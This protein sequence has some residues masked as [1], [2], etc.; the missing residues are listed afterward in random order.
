MSKNIRPQ[1]FLR[2]LQRDTVDCTPVW[3]M[4]QAGRYLPEYKEIRKQAGDFL[5]LCKTPELAREVTLQPLNR[6][7]LDAA[8][9]FSD[10]LTIPDAMG[11]ALTIE[12]NY[13][14]QFKRPLRS[15]R[16]INNLRIPDIDSELGYVMETIKI[17]RAELEEQVPLIGFSG[18]PWTL[19]T[20][21]IDRNSRD[22]FNAIKR[23]LYEQPSLL[24]K[25]LNVLT[26]SIARYLIAQAKAGAQTLMIFDTWGGVLAHNDYLEFSLLPISMIIKELK[27]H[28]ESKQI[29]IILFTKGGNSWITQMADTGCTAIG[30]DWTMPLSA[31]RKLVN[32]RVALQGNLDPA[33]LF[34]S[35]KNIEAQVKHVLSDF[36][37]GSGHVFN[38][39]HGIPPGVNPGH[40]ATLVD[41]VHE[42]SQSGHTV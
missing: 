30:C 24:Q 25:L 8:I 3:L 9:V 22:D 32:N 15:E 23:L 39:G 29:P 19:A 6:F 1:R 12:E 28:N 33:I 5:T 42:F 34:T 27:Q 40:V 26:E 17:V 35:P 20:Y 38:L 41:A 18:S 10:I 21:M 37:N 7:D 13:G 31:A 2:A 14:P 11:L 4:R 16:D 36:G